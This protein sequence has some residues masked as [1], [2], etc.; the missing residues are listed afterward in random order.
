MECDGVAARA[1]NRWRAPTATG[2]RTRGMFAT[3]VALRTTTTAPRHPASACMGNLDEDGEDY[4]CE[5]PHPHHLFA[6]WRRPHL[7]LHR[8]LHMPSPTAG[9]TKAGAGGRERPDGARP[10]GPGAD[11][12]CV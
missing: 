5:A 12:L 1:R 10:N 6:H 11:E 7:H 4:G 8:L 3:R 2:S 9:T